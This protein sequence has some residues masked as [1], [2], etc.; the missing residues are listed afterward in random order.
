[1]SIIAYAMK[2]RSKPSSDASTVGKDEK[3]ML[4]LARK[5]M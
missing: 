5:Q 1:M 3:S 4:K 2:I